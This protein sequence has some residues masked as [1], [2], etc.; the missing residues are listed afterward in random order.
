MILYS[1]GKVLHG[2]ASIFGI[3]SVVFYFKNSALAQIIP[4]GSLGGAE[5]SELRTDVDVR[6]LP[7]DII[8]GGAVRGNNLFH[9]FSEFNVND[10]Q[11]VYFGNPGGIENIISRVTGNNPSNIFGTLGIDGAG[12]LFFIN[13]NGIVFGEN[14]NLDIAGSFVASTAKSLVFENGF[15]FTTEN[16]AQPPLLTIN[17]PIGLQLGVNS[18]GILL[19]TG[20]DISTTGFIGLIGNGVVSQ[21]AMINGGQI[22]IG[23][24]GDESRIGI[25]QQDSEFKFKY[26]EVKELANIVVENTSNFEAIG[27]D[28]TITGLDITVSG[29]SIIF[30]SQGSNLMINGRDISFSSDSRISS[31]FGNN[32]TIN[33]RDITF[34][35]DINIL[36]FGGNDLTIN[37]RNIN[38]LDQTDIFLVSSG[39]L[40]INGERINILGNGYLYSV[41]SKDLKITTDILSVNGGIIYKEKGQGDLTIEANDSLEVVG[42]PFQPFSGSIIFDK[43][44]LGDDAAIGGGNLTISTKNLII[45]DGGQIQALTDSSTF[46]ASNILINATESIEVTGRVQLDNDRFLPSQIIAASGSTS[47]FPGN[48][49]SENDVVLA[50]AGGNLTINTGKLTV[51]NRGEV[52][53]RSTTLGDAGTLT[54]NAGSI[55]LDEGKITATSD[56]A[57]G[58]NI[59]LTASDLLLMRDNSLISAQSFAT[60]SQDGNIR[61]IDTDFVIALP[62]ENSDIIARSTNQGNI[63]ITA[64][65]VIGYQYG[66]L[67]PLSNITASGTVTLNVPNVDPTQGL[68]QF[69]T[70]LVHP[71]QQIDQ[72]C[73]AREEDESKFTVIGRTGLPQSPNEVL[74]PDMVLDDLGTLAS[75][76]GDAGMRVD[77]DAK[78][79]P[80]TPS[81]SNSQSPLPLI[82]RGDSEFPNR[83]KQ[84]VEAQGW[85]V[86]AQGKVTLVAQAPT[87]IPHPLAVT[88]ASCH[89]PQL[90]HR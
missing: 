48:Q 69:P 10:G 30:T 62:S 60:D 38:I 2:L 73:A 19:L 31:N 3:C 26:D 46:S 15:E 7:G 17:L 36:L 39:N 41:D 5:Q 88:S 75:R 89:T 23:S 74:T 66:E 44:D 16:P 14:A 43:D 29:E 87:V 72:S 79:S 61:I 18:G 55:L 53:V 65:S 52:S 11:R 27:G 82:P 12:S 78:N 47:L 9:S 76:E 84:L 33:G 90:P 8:E 20:S 77:E 58:G 28:L 45:R 22:E 25:T 70:E 50:G 6:G 40:I 13:P 42:V 64:D 35:S 59:N 24:V 63:D 34:S 81:T 21:G 49:P 54:V 1:P 37:G 85:V 67:T 71:S 86:D 32:L 68:T 56:N 80:T 4:D 57:K 51:S 83:P